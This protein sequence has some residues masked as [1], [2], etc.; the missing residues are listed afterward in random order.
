MYV[1]RNERTYVRVVL[2]SSGMINDPSGV[3]P[4]PALQAPPAAVR[5]TNYGHQMRPDLRCT[6]AQPCY[7]LTCDE[8]DAMRD[9]AGDRCEIC[10]RLDVET[11]RG[12]LVIDHFQDEGGPC[13]VRGLLCDRCNSVMQRHDGLAHWGPRSRPW[14]EKA[15]AYHLNAFRRPSEETYR[16]ADE[17]IRQRAERLRRY[18]VANHT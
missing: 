1:R 14:A 18:L 3:L 10:N 6:H 12:E 4:P 9:R 5:R 8:Y 11:P 17:V 7:R 15:R 16:Q 13:F 2:Y